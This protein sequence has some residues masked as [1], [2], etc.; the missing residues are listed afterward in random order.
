M[1]FNGALKSL[2]R[3]IRGNWEKEQ[4]VRR[5][6][7]KGCKKEEVIVIAWRLL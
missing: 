4:I 3:G 1:R 7:N 5:I 6:K 2:V